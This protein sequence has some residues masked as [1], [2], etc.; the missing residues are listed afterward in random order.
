MGNSK[1]ARYSRIG[2]TPHHANNYIHIDMMSTPAST[3][4][5]T[6]KSGYKFNMGVSPANQNSLRYNIKTLTPEI[7]EQFWRTGARTRESMKPPPDPFVDWVKFVRPRMTDLSLSDSNV[8]MSLY[9]SSAGTFYTHY[10]ATS[11]NDFSRNVFMVVEGTPYESD[12]LTKGRSALELKTDFCNNR[13]D[14]SFIVPDQPFALRF[15]FNPTTF[16]DPSKYHFEGVL[17]ERHPLLPRVD[18]EF[19]VLPLIKFDD[20][21]IVEMSANYNVRLG[22]RNLQTVDI[23]FGK[24][25]YENGVA[26]SG[27]KKGNFTINPQIMQMNKRHGGY[28]MNPDTIGKNN[29]DICNN[30]TSGVVI[31]NPPYMIT[32]LSLVDASVLQRVGKPNVSHDVDVSNFKYPHLMY[33]KVVDSSYNTSGIHLT[34]NSS[35]PTNVV[36]DWVERVQF[37]FKEDRDTPSN[38]K[39]ASNLLIEG[40]PGNY[41]QLL[42][43]ICKNDVSLVVRD[44]YFWLRTRLKIPKTCKQIAGSNESSIHFTMDL[45]AN[46]KRSYKYEISTIKFMIGGSLKTIFTG[47]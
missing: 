24:A 30:M 44:S 32:D 46:M 17:H 38:W 33:K 16:V 5:R 41:N 37:S 26:L 21:S 39:D 12:V 47:V 6:F 4:G 43:D 7:R 14:S 42:F 18:P 25:Q 27:F 22:E 35:F 8:H 15:Q 29:I 9:D 28:H 13:M 3:S 1:Q 2:A 10:S 23:S 45:S 19:K 20:G 36:S 11:T 31:Y 34:L 40:V